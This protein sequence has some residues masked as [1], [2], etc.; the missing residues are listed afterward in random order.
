MI[1][2]EMTK[3]LIKNFI[4]TVYISDVILKKQ[5][6]K[7][8]NHKSGESLYIDGAEIYFEVIGKEEAPVLLLL[9][10]DFGTM[11]D[12]NIITEDLSKDFK[13]IGIDSRCHGKSILGSK[14]LTFTTVYSNFETNRK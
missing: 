2:L 10:R 11:E 8:F 13:T 9:H 7:N 5:V 3:H 4:T 1:K 6:I 14:K 12:F